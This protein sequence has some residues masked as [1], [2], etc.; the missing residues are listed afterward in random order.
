MALITAHD[1]ISF[2]RLGQLDPTRHPGAVSFYLCDDLE[3]LNALTGQAQPASG[4]TLTQADLEQQQAANLALGEDRV[5]AFE[6]LLEQSG[7][8][9]GRWAKLTVERT[10]LVE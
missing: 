4:G 5:A 10:G 3:V 7:V 6:A 9:D 2:D 8:Q 1:E